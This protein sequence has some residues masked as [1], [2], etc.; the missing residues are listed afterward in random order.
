MGENLTASP[1]VYAVDGKQH[2]A[3]V[4][5]TAVFAFALHEPVKP[6]P[7]PKTQLR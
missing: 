5:S 7:V 1:V 3:I 2:V 6:V 4:S